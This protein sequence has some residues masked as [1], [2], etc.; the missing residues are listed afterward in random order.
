MSPNLTD[1]V[2]RGRGHPAP[3]LL[4]GH[5]GSMAF[6]SFL[7]EG[8]IISASDEDKTIR[9]WRLS[10]GHSEVV[11]ELVVCAVATSPDRRLVAIGGSDG[12][13]RLFDLETP[14]EVTKS[15]GRHA[16]VIKSLSFSPDSSQLASGALD[17]TI[18][19]WS[20]TTLEQVAGPLK[21]HKDSVWWVCY[22]PDGRKVASCDREV[23]Q[24][25]D[26]T[27][28]SRVAFN[29]Q[30]WSL[31]WSLDGRTLFAGCIDGSIKCYNPDTGVL[32]ASYKG[33]H[34][35]IFSITL[36]HNHK[37]I[38]TASWDKTV[39]LWEANTL[40]QIGPTLPH[41]ARV[42]SISISPDDSHLV[43]GAR[44]STVRVWNLRT[45]APALFSFFPLEPNRG[46]VCSF[47]SSHM[48]NSQPDALTQTTNG[49]HLPWGKPSRDP[50][51]N[52]HEGSHTPDAVSVPSA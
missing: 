31:A 36:S 27:T 9:R 40:Q 23:I 35:V 25:W 4:R 13:V 12:R 17:G 19:V 10:D 33:H 22:S 2:H 39:R 18:L 45:I 16:H 47:V 15:V 6:V 3:T 11:K 41:D 30:A 21:G 32:H 46:L 50:G 7:S 37:F 28:W 24:I 1:V 49:F 34:D 14:A 42:Y 26:S 29:E 43:S 48:A 38:A 5:S 20:S 44:D 8:Q 51:S 52:D